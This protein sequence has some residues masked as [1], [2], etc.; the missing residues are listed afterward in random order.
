MSTK[1]LHLFF[2]LNFWLK[3]AHEIPESVGIVF[4]YRPG[5]VAWNFHLCALEG[6]VTGALGGGK[7]HW[8]ERSLE[9]WGEGR[10]TG[11]F[12]SLQK[13]FILQYTVRT[14]TECFLGP[15]KPSFAQK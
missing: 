14:Q 6:K 4:L 15:G 9:L 7:G 1:P 2:P 12:D 5:R 13:C 11:T 8:R 3:D 10:V